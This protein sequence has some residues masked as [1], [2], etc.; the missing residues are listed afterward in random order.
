MPRDRHA[1][2]PVSPP[3]RLFRLLLRLYPAEFRSVYGDEMVRFF[4]ERR[5]RARERGGRRAVVRLWARTIADLVSTSAA[6]R[7]ASRPGQSAKK[8]GSAMNAL[9]SDVR[10]AARR[11]R[12][13][14][15]FTISAFAI[16]A[17][18]IGLNASVFNLVDT[19]VFRPPP[20][21]DPEEI[22]HVY[23][24]SDEGEPSSTSFPAYR[25]MAERAD[26]FAAVA[27]TSPGRATWE[28]AEGPR[29]AAVEF[30]TASYFAVLG[31]VPQRGRWFSAEHDM[32]GSE[33]V[34]VVSYRTWRSRMGEDPS[35]IGSTIRLNNQPVTIIGVGPTRFN[36]EAGALLTDFWLSISSTPVGGPF[37][38]SNLDRNEDHWYQVKARLA[39]GVTLARAQAAMTQVAQEMAEA[40]P[41]MDR[42]R[43][44]TVF[45]LDEVR[46]HPDVDGGVF[47]AGVGM[48]VVAGL[49]LLLACANLANLLLVRGISRGT[50]MAVRQA[51]GAGRGHVVRLLLLESLLLATAGGLA[52]LALAAWSVRLVPLLPLP[53]PIAGLDVGF[54]HRVVVFGVLLA[55]ATGLL[56]GL[57]PALRSARTELVAALRDEGRG[58]SAGRAVSLLRGGL[59][60]VQVAI[61]VVLVVGAG[62]LA[63]SLANAERVK[64]G[65][66]AD[67]IAVI[68]TNLQQGGV[69]DGEA[70]VVVTQLL[71][72]IEALPGVERAA[73][74]TRLPAER[75]GT[76]TQVVE[77]YEPTAGTGSVELNF[78]VVSRNYFETMGIPLVEGRTFGVDD[79]PESTR[80]IVVNEAAAR[81]FWGG[82]AIGGRIRSQGAPDA[83]RYVVGVVGDVKVN[84][85]REAPVPMIYYSLEQAGA[86]SFHVVVRTSGDPAA[87]IPSVRAALREVRSTLPVTAAMTMRAHLGEGLAAARTAAALM[88]GFSLLA[89]LLASVGVYAVVSFSVERRTQELGIRMALGAARSRVVSMVVGESLIV[90]AVGVT[91]GLGLAALAVRGLQ[92][93]LFGVQA[94]DVFTFSAAAVLLLLSAG[95]A[96]FLPADRAARQDPV[97][98]LRTQ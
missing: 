61:S 62:L 7:R 39:P 63:R 9:G 41:E 71:E 4:G 78:A 19:I 34:A 43:D 29:Q 76:T 79:R 33:M 27:A 21:G 92:S 80:V 72:R 40:Y 53:G 2:D 25:R 56:F 47:A 17:L 28:T 1:R 96:A 66:D 6:E 64:P 88:G 74:T 95:G 69:P 48:L 75:A 83:W 20:F 70:R 36:G 67:R 38:V 42:G 50:E 10:Y 11:L 86:G 98:V 18:G 23:Q 91:A 31:L 84:D 16:L 77:G 89:L 3:S 58:Q 12:R 93:M 55:L 44:I 24:D 37:R 97:S 49:V 30:T 46:L 45:A 52:G 8:G 82:D 90:V 51:I 59:I 57:L 54:N 81:L 73:L 68:G 65:F 94:V 60:A 13:A 87:L 14:P 35:V 5:R 15:V 22:V 32:V 85:L 26:V